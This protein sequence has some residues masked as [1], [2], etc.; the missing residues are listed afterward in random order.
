MILL[1]S[2][3]MTDLLRADPPAMKWFVSLDDDEMY[4]MPLKSKNHDKLTENSE[5]YN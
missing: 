3:V 5:E 1:D 4:V 2:D